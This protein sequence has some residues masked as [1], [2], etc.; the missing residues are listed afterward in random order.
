MRRA[1]TR[2]MHGS[3]VIASAKIPSSFGVPWPDDV[4]SWRNN[5]FTDDAGFGGGETISLRA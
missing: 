2:F 3:R 5:D 4:A 1:F